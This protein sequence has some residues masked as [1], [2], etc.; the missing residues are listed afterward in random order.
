MSGMSA[1]ESSLYSI[2]YFSGIALKS[3]ILGG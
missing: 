3:G 2:I 1:D